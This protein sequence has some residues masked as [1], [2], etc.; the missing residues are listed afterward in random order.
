MYCAIIITST[1]GMKENL[2]LKSKENS[3]RRFPEGWDRVGTMKGKRR[4]P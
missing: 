3:G 4:I 2:S 1:D